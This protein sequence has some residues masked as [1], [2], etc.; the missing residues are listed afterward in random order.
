MIGMMK[1]GWSW[2]RLL[3]PIVSFKRLPTVVLVLPTLALF[4]VVKVE[5]HDPGLSAA[6]LR[7]QDSAVVANVTFARADVESVVKIDGDRD[8]EIS[9]AEFG[10]ARPKLE[11]L[12]ASSLELKV[13]GRLMRLS[14]S[15]V[16]LDESSAVHFV[17][18][19]AAESGSEFSVSSLLI[20]R[21]ARGHR[22]Y[23][24][25]SD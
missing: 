7:L 8:G 18:T 22:Q 19:F 23:L 6:D 5:A 11:D 16:T 21:L 3:R 20:A 24:S 4:L 1:A 17:I 2:D 9:P 15:S 14:D 12:A 10:V 25:V 13:D